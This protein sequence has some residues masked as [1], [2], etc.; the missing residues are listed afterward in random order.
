[1]AN[2]KGEQLEPGIWKHPEGKGYLAEINYTDPQTGRRIREQK[3]T[4]RL[5]LAREWRQTRKADALRGEV[6]RRKDQPRAMRFEQ[7]AEEYLENWS[8]VEKAASTHQRDI[9][10][11]KHL[12]GFFGSRGIAE[13][14]RRD[15]EQYVAQRKVSGAQPGTLNRE[16]SCL[17]NM[18]RKAVDWEYLE[19]NPAWGVS[20]QREEVIEFEFVREEEIPLLIDACPAHLKPVV[21]FALQTGMRRGEI[22]NLQWQDVSFDKGER[23]LI[24]VRKTKNHETR[25]I[26]MTPLVRE[27]L[28][29][30]PRN[31]ASGK[32]ASFVFARPDG[33][34]I[35]SIRNGFEAAVRRSKLGK[36][37]RFHDLRHTFASLLVMKGVDLR[38]VAKLM[39]HRDIRVTMRYAH[40]APEHLQAAVDVLARPSVQSEQKAG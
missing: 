14:K 3:S 28:Q 6:R 38:T 34:G 25:Y 29:D 23:G 17:K 20:Q 21:I 11:M 36:H 31:I 32:D 1:M 18:L 13:I 37:I 27:T 35:K 39:G 15:V 33:E 19:A 8:R 9:N 30:L 40:L 5:D 22:L 12:N 24:T 2:Q 4:H 26:P 7:L 16:L 10:S